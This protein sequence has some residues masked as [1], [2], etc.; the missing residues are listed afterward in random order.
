MDVAITAGI[1]DCRSIQHIHV[2]SGF[3]VNHKGAQSGLSY[4][5][6]HSWAH[7]GLHS[8]YA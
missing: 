3:L 6:S 2:S 5:C 1:L 7:I 4:S 8:S